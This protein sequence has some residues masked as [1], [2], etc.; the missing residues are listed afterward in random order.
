M[1][2]SLA[3]LLTLSLG[4]CQSTPTDASAASEATEVPEPRYRAEPE[5]PAP[6]TQAFL[7]DSVLMADEI[8]VE[9]P[10]GL[11]EHL[12]I[13]QEPSFHDHTAKTVE[14]GFLQES[15]SKG[16]GQAPIRAKLD[17]LTLAAF[18]RLTVLERVVGGDV[19]VRAIGDAQ[20]SELES[21]EQRSAA[22][23]VLR[24]KQP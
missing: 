21:G 11:I 2:T 12:A 18:H 9:G 3:L 24:G 20:F 17:G 13:R 6:W 14:S 15:V 22:S 4:A 5:P 10:P 1:R 16:L 8:R 23:L 19:V 7:A